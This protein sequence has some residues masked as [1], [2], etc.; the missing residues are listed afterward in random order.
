M[1]IAQDEHRTKLI[2]QGTR[3]TEIPGWRWEKGMRDL[4]E[5]TF[6]EYVDGNDGA[7]L[8]SADDGC[9]YF[10]TEGQI[11]DLDWP[12]VGGF[13]LAWLG[14]PDARVVARQGGVPKYRLRHLTETHDIIEAEAWGPIAFACTALAEKLGE[15]PDGR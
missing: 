9:E 6:I 8:W 15:W 2:Q 14:Y 10:A 13:M 11:P 3:A 12:A 4:D 1:S 5:N 7:W